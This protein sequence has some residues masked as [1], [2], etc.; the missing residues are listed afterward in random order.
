VLVSA[1]GF[2]G[3][4]FGPN[5]TELLS[6]GF[7]IA[8]GAFVAGIGLASMP[9]AFEVIGKVRSIRDFF[10]TLFF[11]SLGVQ[12]TNTSLLFIL[13]PLLIL[14]GLILI[15]KPIITFIIVTSFGYTKKTSFEAASSLAQT[16]EFSLII[17]ASGFVLGHI[18]QDFISMAVIL[19]LVTII[20]TSYGMKFNRYIYSKLSSTLTI[21]ERIGAKSVNPGYVP[22]ENIKNEVLLIGFDRIGYNIYETLKRL[23]KN[24]LI[25]DFNPDVIHKLTKDKIHCIYGDIGDEEIL[26]R[27]NLHGAKIVIST[28]PDPENTEY[29]ILQTRKV[30]TNCTLIVTAYNVDEA[31]EFYE[32]GADYVVLPHLLGGDHASLI[33]E[34]FNDDFNSIIKAKHAHINELN[35]RIKLG[36]HSSIKR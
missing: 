33:L 5:M 16:S 3:I 13:K 24:F 25:V 17:V 18:S 34:Q 35:K 36:H 23:K 10:A 14:L 4:H 30:N 31:L 27:V 15:I 7:S 11:I 9:Y 2:I 21:F 28:I 29:L 12:L 1:L 26:S 32:K 8:M 19:S 22:E 20:T 6:G